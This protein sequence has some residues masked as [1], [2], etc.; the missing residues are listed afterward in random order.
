MEEHSSSLECVQNFPYQKDPKAPN[1][2]E[3]PPD[4]IEGEPEWEVESIV[5]IRFIYGKLQFLVKWLGWF[6]AENSWE[7]EANLEHSQDIINNFYTKFPAAPRRLPSG[8][9]TGKPLTK[10]Q[11]R[12]RKQ[13]GCLEH[14]PME[15]YTDVQDWPMGRMTRDE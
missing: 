10:G 2:P 5:D 13:I 11:K 6:D 8:S 9:K 3:P 1:H 12:G 15:I 4:I 14:E 7:D